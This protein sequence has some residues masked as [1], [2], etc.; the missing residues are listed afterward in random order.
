MV[1]STQVVHNDEWLSMSP[2]RHSIAFPYNPVKRSRMFTKCF[3][4]AVLPL[5]EAWLLHSKAVR[6]PRGPQV[7]PLWPMHASL[8]EE[9]H[10]NRIL[11][12]IRPDLL[13]GNW[14]RRLWSPL[15][16]KAL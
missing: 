12:K 14:S 9:P 10:K 7:W 4:S 6:L 3:I 13:D 1:G 2:F 11:F 8:V 16:P 15:I 5:A